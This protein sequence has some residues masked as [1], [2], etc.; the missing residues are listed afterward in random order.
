M[1]RYT[2][3]PEIGDTLFHAR[4]EL[5]DHRIPACAGSDNQVISAISTNLL[6][7]ASFHPTLPVYGTARLNRLFTSSYLIVR[8]LPSPKLPSPLLYPS[9]SEFRGSE[10]GSDNE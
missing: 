3:A 7:S 5:S 4:I 10:K 9:F 1:R 6:I 8:E 2:L